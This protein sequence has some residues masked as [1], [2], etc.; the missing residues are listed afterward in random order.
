MATRRDFVISVAASTLPGIISSGVAG[1]AT[2]AIAASLRED[3]WD[4]GRLAHLLPTVSVRLFWDFLRP[5]DHARSPEAPNE[6]N[7]PEQLIP[8]RH[9]RPF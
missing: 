1:P 7:A 4:Q 3:T 8:P 6:A 2:A 5:W 9:R